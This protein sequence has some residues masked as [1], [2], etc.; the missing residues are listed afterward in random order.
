MIEKRQKQ[1]YFIEQLLI[2]VDIGNSRLKIKIKNKAYAFD[3]IN[4]WEKRAVKLIESYP[5]QDKLL[6]YSSVNPY[7]LRIFRKAVEGKVI[8][9]YNVR[10]LTVEQQILN[11]R[12]IKGIGIDRVLGMIGAL[13]KFKPPLITV[14]CGTAITINAVDKDNN[15]LGG[16]IL[17]GIETQ[18]K[19]LKEHTAGMKDIE[20]S[21]FLKKVKPAKINVAAGKDTVSAIKTGVIIG[22]AA[23]IKEI[24]TMIIKQ[25]FKNDKVQLIL[26]GGTVDLVYEVLKD[27]DFN[28]HIQSDLVLDGIMLLLKGYVILVMSHIYE[29]L[30]RMAEEKNKDN[31]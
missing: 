3:Y 13:E 6:C 26:T 11:Y 9:S 16:A 25:E 30:K 20:I 24:I 31:C 15:C 19:S 14:D 5:E 29:E 17:P 1:K 7:R 10:E 28:F 27:S 18:I 12:Q 23:T 4:G 22:A 21:P 2:A 8:N